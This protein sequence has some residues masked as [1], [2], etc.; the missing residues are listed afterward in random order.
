MVITFNNLQL[1]KEEGDEVI[2]IEEVKAYLKISGV[3]DDSKILQLIKSAR[4]FAE[5]LCGV[6]LLKQ[7]YLIT[8]L[9]WL[10]KCNQ[11]IFPITLVNTIENIEYTNSRCQTNVLDRQYYCF[12]SESQILTLKTTY[13]FDSLKITFITKPEIGNIE[14]FKLLLLQHISLLYEIDTTKKNCKTVEVQNKINNLY[15]SYRL[16]RL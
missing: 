15:S 14:K 13:N 12:D 6:S 4:R 2:T 5:D 7:T 10:I 1:I 11:I 16:L 8:Y 3:I 9:F